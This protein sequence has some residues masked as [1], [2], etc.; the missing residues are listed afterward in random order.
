MKLDKIKDFALQYQADASFRAEADA[1]PNAALKKAGFNVP[2]GINLK[3]VQNTSTTTYVSFPE[4]PND[5]LKDESLDSLAGGYCA[6]TGC[7]PE[8]ADGNHKPSQWEIDLNDQ[9]DLGLY[10]EGSTIYD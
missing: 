5:M 8:T 6:C 9:Y 4:D 3:F 7:R 2:E 10:T 1:N